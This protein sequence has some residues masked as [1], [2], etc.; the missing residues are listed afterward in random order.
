MT[1]ATITISQPPAMAAAAARFLPSAS[2][3]RDRH[4]IRPY[5]T[6]PGRERGQRQGELPGLAGWRGEQAGGGHGG[7]G[8]QRRAQAGHE[9][10]RPA[11][12]RPPSSSNSSLARADS[13]GK[14][15]TAIGTASTA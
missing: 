4:A 1:S 13:T 8:E 3:T 15:L 6:T 5:P 7:P 12:R 11:S 2:S 9:Q 14:A 10:H